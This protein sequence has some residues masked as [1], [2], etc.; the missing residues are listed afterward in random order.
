[1]YFF[2]YNEFIFNVKIWVC[3]CYRFYVRNVKIEGNIEKG[4]DYCIYLF[5]I[6]WSFCKLFFNVFIEK[7][8]ENIRN[9][10]FCYGV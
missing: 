2:L 6:N 8:V 9:I 4:K 1:M 7:N 10:L 5:N 3:E